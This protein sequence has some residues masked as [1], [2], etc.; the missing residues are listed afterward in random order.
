M[1]RTP[2]AGKE[3]GASQPSETGR[4]TPTLLKV[5][6]MTEARFLGSEHSGGPR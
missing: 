6:I 5:L 4:R 3:P 1:I 2:A